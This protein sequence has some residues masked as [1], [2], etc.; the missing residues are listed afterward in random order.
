MKRIDEF[1]KMKKDGKKISMVTCYDY[2]SARIATHSEIDVILVGDSASMV[3]HG[4]DT[5]LNA[6]LEMMSSHVRA[7]RKGAPDK[8]IIG[9]MPFLAHRKGFSKT[10]DAVDGLMKSGAEAVKIEG[11]AGQLDIISHIVESGVPVMGHLGLTPQSLHKLGG[12]KVQGKNDETAEKM[13]R[14]AKSLEDTGVFSLVLELVPAQLAKEITE[15]LVIPT[16]GIGAGPH[17]SGQVLV[18]QDVLGMNN[19]FSPK[20]LRT[21]LDGNK[22][23]Q[24]ALNQFN[25]EV[26]DQSFPSEKE[27]F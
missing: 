4:Y 7:V 3:M 21:Y 5:T 22:L 15:S 24:D 2:T 14:D 26:K 25:K 9:D 16:I 1:V 23:I 6:T 19:G 20:F 12:Y 18:W 11:A 27:S 8:F 10:M 13:K 17:T